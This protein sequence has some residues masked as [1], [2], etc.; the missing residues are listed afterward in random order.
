MSFTKGEWKVS[1]SGFARY[2]TFGRT[3][4]GARAFV[5]GEELDI[6]AEAQG[7]TEE[8]AQANAHLIASAPAMAKSGRELDVAIGNAIMKIAQATALSNALIQII[9]QDILP[10]QIKWREALAKAEG[11]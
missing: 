6:I 10:A 3:K 8:E 1:E 9:K 11:K 5:V 7:D 2:S 4:T